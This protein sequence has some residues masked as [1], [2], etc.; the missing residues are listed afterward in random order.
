MRG[1]SLARSLTV[2][3][4]ALFLFT[5]CPRQDALG[6]SAMSILGKGIINDPKNKSLRFDLLKFGLDEF[7]KEM[8]ERGAP[9]KLR[10]GEPVLGRFFADGCNSQIID[11]DSR[12]SFVMQYSGRGYGWTN[13]TQKL[14]FTSS[15]IVEYAPDF[16]LA[17]GAMYIYFRPRNVASASFQTLVVEGSL[18]RTGLAVTGVN[19]DQLGKDIVDSQLKRGFTVIRYGSTGE[20]EFGSGY[21]PVG[22]KPFRPFFVQSADKVTLDNDRTE[23]HGNQ[24]DL[25]GGFIV[26]D[27]DQALYLTMQVDGA[28]AV[29][30]FVIPKGDGD[31]FLD[32][33]ARAAGPATLTSPPVFTDS[34]PAGQAYKRKFAVP[35]GTY[36]LLLDN[37]PAIGGAAPPAIVGDDRAARVDYVVELGDR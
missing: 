8:R 27:D 21:I 18:A 23:V 36:Y 13:V 34:V 7:C 20:T 26:P 10:D 28:P 2:G 37:S 30:A 6:I 3:I 17:D 33:Y 12:Q 4:S 1:Q 25:I 24:Q 19:P 22:K 14:G 29:D 31:A 15:G 32:R 11:E 35:K 9:L 5:G 16:Q